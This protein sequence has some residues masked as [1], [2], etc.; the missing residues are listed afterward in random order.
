MGE[1]VETQVRDAV[2]AFTTGDLKLAEAVIARENEVNAMELRLD[3]EC[4][5]LIAM[6][7]P[8]AVDLRRVLTLAKVVSN[9]EQVGDHAKKI[10][11][12]TV[13]IGDMNV[14]HAR[15]V[16][17]IEALAAVAR[18]AARRSLRTPPR[19]RSGADGHRSGAGPG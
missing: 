5:E 19:R 16:V 15:K 14:V 3:N 4:A 13:A 11:K 1:L 6:R 7:Q 17:E 18:R 8:A 2:R 9:L 10:A 12:Y